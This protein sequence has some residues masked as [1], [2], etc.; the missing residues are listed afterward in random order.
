MQID[1][2]THTSSGCHLRHADFGVT[3]HSLLLLQ[4]TLSVF[5]PRLESNQMLP[6]RDFVRFFPPAGKQS[7]A[8]SM[9]AEC[10]F[11][12]GFFSSQ[13]RISCPLV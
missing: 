2:Q 12:A 11:A 6:L 1:R 9:K 13:T 4:E 3:L 10:G 5:F 7:D 8:I